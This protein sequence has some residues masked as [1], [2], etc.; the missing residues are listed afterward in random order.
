MN[1]LIIITLAYKKITKNKF[2]YSV[3]FPPAEYEHESHS[4]P[5]RPVFP[6]FYDKDLKINNIGCLQVVFMLKLINKFNFQHTRSVSQ[7]IFFTFIS[8][9][10]LQ[11]PCI[12][13]KKNKK[14]LLSGKGMY[15][16]LALHLSNFFHVADSELTI[17]IVSFLLNTSVKAIFPYHNQLSRKCMLKSEKES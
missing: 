8:K 12:P 6:E 9:F 11:I 1:L 10:K 15:I 5:S 3:S 14:S 17:L 16:T 13:K 4:C 2:Q 7:A